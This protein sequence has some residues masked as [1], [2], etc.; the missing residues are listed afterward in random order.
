MTFAT[1]HAFTSMDK[2]F[3]LQVWNQELKEPI[4]LGVE[5]VYHFSRQTKLRQMFS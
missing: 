3:M 5:I 2:N 4:G 1:F